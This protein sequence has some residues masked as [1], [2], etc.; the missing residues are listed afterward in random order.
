MPEAGGLAGR[1]PRQHAGRICLTTTPAGSYPRCFPYTRVHRPSSEPPQPHLT[2]CCKDTRG[3][4]VALAV[5]K[6]TC[7][8]M[9][10]PRWRGVLHHLSAQAEPCYHLF[11]LLPLLMG[12][13]KDYTAG[14]TAHTHSLYSEGFVLFPKRARTP[15]TAFM[16]VPALARAPAAHTPRDHYCIKTY[17]RSRTPEGYPVLDGH[18]S[19]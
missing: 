8:N 19:S 14:F 7:I 17:Q 1:T 11:Y 3:A 18:S 2:A 4:P 6:D 16:P 5:T 9:N 12:K 13:K 10:M 15:F